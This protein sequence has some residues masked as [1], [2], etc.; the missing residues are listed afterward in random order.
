MNTQTHE[1]SDLETSEP[2]LAKLTGFDTDGWPLVNDACPSRSLVAL[3]RSLVGSDVVVTRFP[4]DPSRMLIIGVIQ[5]PVQE[6]NQGKT[7][8]EAD[9]E[10]VLRCGKSS[11]SLEKGG[12]ITIR[13]KQL[14]SRA[15]GQNRVQGA[16]VSLN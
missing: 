7:V 11:V 14:L 2:R 1:F 9:R 12:K 4:G 16:N 5:P 6:G 13:G 3:D 15:D 10:L 8:I